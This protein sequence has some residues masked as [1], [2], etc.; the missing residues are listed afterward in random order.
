MDANNEILRLNFEDFLWLIF[1]ILSFLNIRGDCDDK[2]YIVNNCVFCKD[3]ANHIFTFTLT[4]TLII[5]F[6][7]FVRNYKR[8]QMADPRQKEVYLVKVYGSLFL[9]VGVFC[10]LYFQKKQIYF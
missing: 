3:E 9:I 1:V 7:F 5:Y 10:L 6:Y 2:K 8:Y 4:V